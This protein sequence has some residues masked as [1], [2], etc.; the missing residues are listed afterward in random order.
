LKSKNCFVNLD[1]SEGVLP[2]FVADS[3]AETLL[4]VFLALEFNDL[5]R[6]SPLELLFAFIT[7]PPRSTCPDPIV[8]FIF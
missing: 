8:A 3:T 4:V 5:Y 1:I 7:L 2:F 6:I